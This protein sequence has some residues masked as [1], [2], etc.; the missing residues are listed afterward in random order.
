MSGAG[1]AVV[2]VT[3]LPSAGKST[4]A[5]ALRERLRDV[6]RPALLLD[7][8]AVRAALV[9]PPG[10]DEAGRAAFYATL[11]ALAL[12]AAEDGLVSVVAATA[13]RRRFRDAVRERAPRFVEV[14]VATPPAVCAARDPKGLWARARAGGAPE[15]PGGG[16]PYE[17]PLVPEVVATDGRDEGALLAALAGLGAG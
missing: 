11:G 3:G 13:P 4:F 2:W 6:G 9:P 1:G 12:L 15:L 8:D 7:G 16:V 14:H 17:P 5:R 10:Y